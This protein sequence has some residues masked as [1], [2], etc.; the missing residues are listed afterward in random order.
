MV[1]KLRE[2]WNRMPLAVKAATAY[3]VCNVL[4]KCLSFIT[5]PLFTRLLTKEQYGQYTVYQSWQGIF[6]IFLTLNLAYG[7]FSRAMVKFEKDR[8]GYIASIQGVCLMLSLVFLAVYLPFTSVWNQLLNLPTTLVLLMVAEILMHTAVMFWTGKERF[9]YHYKGIVLL[10][11]AI[12]V[13][14]PVIAFVLVM[15]TEEK[16]IARIIGYVIPTVVFGLALFILNWA[17]GKTLFKKE[18]WKYARSFN[19]PLLVYYLSQTIFNQ[20]DRIM[21]ERMVGIGEA[22][23]YGVAY[24]LAMILTFVLNAINNSY[25]PWYYEKIRQKKEREN[26]PVS[27]V[28]AVLMAVLL[29]LVI[30]FA[31]EIIGIMAGGAYQG[32]EYVVPPVAMSLLLLFYSQLFINVEFFYEEKKLLVISSVAAA[33]LN[34]VLNA[35]LIPVL[36]YVIAGYTTLVSYV[37]FAFCNYLAMKAVLKKK[38][39]K[40]EAYDY[41]WLL[42]VLAGFLILG[43]SGLL[44]YRFLIPRIAFA[45]IAVVLMI[46]FRKKLFGFWKLLKQKDNTKTETETETETK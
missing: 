12:A 38:G 18:Y 5:M 42:V 43:F 6:S 32:A 8:N 44:L 36:G 24:N 9:D 35:L 10:T 23:M 25:L 2:K 45:V 33:V 13:L 37:V 17:R 40:D 46:V 34:V 41:R 31:P 21:I 11:L 1:G 3:T 14:S 7:S 4:L 30:W 22:A 19:L 15:N 27:L 20:S 16:G 29:L 39:L 28:I 26:R